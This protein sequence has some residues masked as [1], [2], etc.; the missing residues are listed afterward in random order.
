MRNVP[1]LDK[2][3]RLV[4]IVTRHD[5]L[6]TLLRP[7]TEIREEVV[8]EVL[9]RGL[10]LMTDTI[11]VA[12]TEGVV[13]LEGEPERKSETAMAVAMT[14]KTD[15][16]VDVVDRLTHRFDDSGFR[17]ATRVPGGVADDWLRRL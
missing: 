16:V 13:T 11:D 1:V 10:W 4:A 12:V 2:D 3:D 9:Q 6:Q 8:R 17:D 5:L 7:D 15:G 14:R